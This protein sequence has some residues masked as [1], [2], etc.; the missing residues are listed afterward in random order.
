MLGGGGRLFKL[1]DSLSLIIGDFFFVGIIVL[2]FGVFMIGGVGRFGYFCFFDKLGGVIVI[3]FACLSIGVIVIGC[4]GIRK[5]CGV[6]L[7]L[8]GDFVDLIN[9]FGF[10]MGVLVCGVLGVE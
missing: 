5:F 6:E 7:M 3:R 10:I 4:G 1:K 2:N 9:S 8:I